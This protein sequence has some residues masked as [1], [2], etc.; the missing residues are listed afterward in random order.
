MVENLPMKNDCLRPDDKNGKMTTK[1]VIMHKKE[2]P[3]QV[4]LYVK[5]DCVSLLCVPDMVEYLQYF[6]AICS[7]YVFAQVILWQKLE[8]TLLL[9]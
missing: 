8:D 7:Q 1:A 5:K 2:H 6:P 4:V 3:K 9:T